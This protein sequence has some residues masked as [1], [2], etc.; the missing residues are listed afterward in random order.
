MLFASGVLP[1]KKEE[2]KK[3]PF[4]RQPG[5]GPLAHL[6]RR[7][8]NEGPHAH[9]RPVLVLTAA[10]PG[11]SKGHRA[12]VWLSKG[13]CGLV[14]RTSLDEEGLDPTLSERHA[15]VFASEQHESLVV[16]RLSEAAMAVTRSQ[17]GER[18]ALAAVGDAAVVRP[19]DFIVRRGGPG[20][21][22]GAVSGQ[23]HHLQQPPLL[24]PR[25]VP[26]TSPSL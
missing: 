16:L 5:E 1:R 10:P 23:H 26:S 12:R 25:H 22:A 6:R 4:E 8:G 24:F 14:K 21:G 15:V 3:Q 18:R 19:G 7:D 13:T 9:M 11:G 17:G 20:R 2:E